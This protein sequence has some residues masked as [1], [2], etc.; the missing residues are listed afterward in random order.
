[1]VVNAAAYRFLPL[2]KLKELRDELKELCRL[3][4]LKGTILL[5]PE[6]LN[7]FV[8]GSQSSVD[9]LLGRLPLQPA[10]IKLSY[11]QTQPYSRMLVRL[12]KEII[13]FGRPTTHTAP[14]L[15][16]YQLKEWLDQGR[17]ITLLDTRNDYEVRMGTFRGAVDLKLSHFRDFPEAVARLGEELKNTPVVTFCTGGIRC[18]KAAPWLEDQG[19]TQVWQ[20]DGGIL[21]YFEE[22]GG[23][24]YIGECFVFDRRVGVDPALE[25]TDS[26]VC[27]VC[28]AP[29][30][31]QQQE[32]P[33]YRR[34]H[35]CPHCFPTASPLELRQQALERVS[36]PLPGSRPAENQV[37]LHIPARCQG[38]RLREALSQ[39][40]PQ[41]KD[42]TNL[43]DANGQEVDWDRPVYGGERYLRIHQAQV[44]PEVCPDIRILHM[45]EAIL[46]LNKPAPLPMHPCGRFARN[47]LRHLLE[48]AFAPEV[49][50]PAHRLDANTTGLLVCARNH[51]FARRLQSQFSQGR[52]EKHYLARVHG[53]PGQDEFEVDLPVSSQAGEG[54]LRE[55]GHGL[56]ARTLFRVRERREDGTSLVEAR[57]L[58]GRT[59]Q[60]RLHLWS[61]GHPVLGDP[62]YL[63]GGLQSQ[64]QTLTMLDPPMCLHSWKICLRHPL[65]GEPFQFECHPP[66]L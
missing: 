40:F 38:M 30:S 8:A 32:D 16:P 33:R 11:S 58:T 25:E 20:L 28:L 2:E 64:R 9:E 60:I 6:G 54:G 42:W 14:R 1:M 13:A 29:L 61:L 17:P 27:P 26:V 53:H 39:L 44:E 56:A 50:R 57:P 21:R 45:D 55:A 47:T 10:H 23:A 34:G 63:P 18:E 35:S 37:P 48:L 59:N 46:L 65:T 3:L 43:R 31:Q 66:I 5:A 62:S 49:P 52:V 24:H 51:H 7:V 15:A 12:K 22:V 4:S 41:V 36:R 19:F